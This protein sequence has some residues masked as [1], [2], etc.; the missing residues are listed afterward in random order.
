M[1]FNLSDSYGKSTNVDNFTIKSSKSK[2]LLGLTFDN[3]TKLQSHI[4]NLCFEATRNLHALARR[5][6]YNESFFFSFSV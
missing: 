3:K 2:N 5:A 1:S 6:P 4:E